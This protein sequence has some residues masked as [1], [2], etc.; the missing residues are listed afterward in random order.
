MLKFHD[1]IAVIDLN[2]AYPTV[3]EDLQVWTVILW[4][5]DLSIGNICQNFRYLKRML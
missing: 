1:G 2:D 5:K 3:M 4:I